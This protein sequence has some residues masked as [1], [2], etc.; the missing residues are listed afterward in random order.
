MIN[1]KQIVCIV[2]YIIMYYIHVHIH[3]EFT[4]LESI[5]KGISFNC[6][7]DPMDKSL[8]TSAVG[9]DI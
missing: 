2:F 5:S 3:N 6:L 9:H 8:A 4:I 1:N 7:Y